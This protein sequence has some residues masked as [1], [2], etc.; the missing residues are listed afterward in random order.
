MYA[1]GRAVA[2]S[3]R[4]S[5]EEVGARSWPQLALPWRPGPASG[6]RA[7]CAGAIL[8]QIRAPAPEPLH[9]AVDVPIQEPQPRPRELH[10]L[11]VS[12]RAWVARRPCLG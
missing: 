4:L 2:T 10:R 6:V 9:Q 8:A 3:T 1:D 11:C 7:P 5:E 12:G